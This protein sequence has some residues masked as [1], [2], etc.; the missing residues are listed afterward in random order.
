MRRWRVEGPA[1]VVDFQLHG[2]ETDESGLARAAA[3]LSDDEMGRAGRL[4]FPEDQRRFVMA[5]ATLRRILADYIGSSAPSHIR[6]EYSQHGKPGLSWS[7]DGARPSFNA[8]HS[9]ER[10]L[11]GVVAEGEI[12]VDIECHRPLRDQ[13]ALVRRYFSDAENEAYFRLPTESR[14][15][16]FFG[17]WTRKE[18]FVKALGRGL[19]FPL[20]DFDVEF[21]NGGQGLSRLH[22]DAQAPRRWT[23]EGFEPEVGYSAAFALHGRFGRLQRTGQCDR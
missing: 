4:R 13:D 21:T 7:G 19:T 22:G 20:R 3:L 16:G 18:A 10:L 17:C 1:G 14:A 11:V 5:R 9:G 6:F 23:L 15:A 2:L 8:S 12:G